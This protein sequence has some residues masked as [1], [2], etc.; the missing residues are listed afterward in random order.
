MFRIKFYIYRTNLYECLESVITF[1]MIARIQSYTRIIL[2]DLELLPIS[3]NIRKGISRFQNGI[4][5][6]SALVGL[7]KSEEASLVPLAPLL[8][9][10]PV[11]LVS[12]VVCYRFADCC[13]CPSVG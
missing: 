7:R 11:L 2:R 6:I 10:L 8:L 3:V 13:H 1:W 9:L 4:E 12:L 5:H